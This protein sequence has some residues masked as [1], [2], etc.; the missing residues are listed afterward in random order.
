MIPVEGE[1]TDRVRATYAASNA[2]H[3]TSKAIIQKIADDEGITT[4]KVRNILQY[5]TGYV[6]W[7]KADHILEK[8]APRL[9]EA[10]A[11]FDS[12]LGESNFLAERDRLVKKISEEQYFT[13]KAVI[14]Y[15]KAHDFWP[16][17]DEDRADYTAKVE[18]AEREEQDRQRRNAEWQRYI[19]QSQSSPD[20]LD[21]SLES[22]P[23]SALPKV[24]AAVVV[25]VV[26]VA[27]FAFASNDDRSTAP[28]YQASTVEPSS[29]PS[30]AGLTSEQRERY[31]DLSPEGK[32]YFD[33]QM[34]KYDEVCAGRSDC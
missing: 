28:T 27:V 15:A 9:R 25:L 23:T 34:Q 2:T 3:E 1:Q 30:A 6:R 8:E 33:S 5:G 12:K 20:T 16:W 14:E 7:T 13:P 32:E 26:C 24:V 31:D 4:A 10:F 19:E 11:E 17:T 21:E 18:A 22:K 29:S